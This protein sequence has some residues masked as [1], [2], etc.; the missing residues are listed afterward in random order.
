MVHG[1]NLLGI[2]PFKFYSL[3][4]ELEMP[5]FKFGRLSIFALFI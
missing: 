1:S 5:R 3:E 4:K 2:R